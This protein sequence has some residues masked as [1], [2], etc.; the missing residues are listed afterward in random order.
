MVFY[1]WFEKFNPFD[2][3]NSEMKSLANGSTAKDNS[4]FNFDNVESIGQA[5]QQSIE[6]LPITDAE[7]AVRKKI[8]TLVN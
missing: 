2:T 3:T 6:N 4:G 1:N 5:L 7:I 8:K